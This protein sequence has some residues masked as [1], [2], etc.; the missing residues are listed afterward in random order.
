MKAARRDQAGKL[1]GY[2]STAK[3]RLTLEALARGPALIHSG[4][5][6]TKVGLAVVEGLG[7]APA[8]ADT[9]ARGD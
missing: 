6:M 2:D 4:Q 3:E 9:A 1:T 7:Q 8:P 5:I